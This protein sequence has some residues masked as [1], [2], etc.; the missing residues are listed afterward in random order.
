M[1]ATSITCCLHVCTTLEIDN[2]YVLYRMI[3]KACELLYSWKHVCG[4]NMY[5]IA[6]ELEITGTRSGHKANKAYL[7]YS[8]NVFEMDEMNDETKLLKLNRTCDKSEKKPRCHNSQSSSSVL[9]TVTVMLY[10]NAMI[11]WQISFQVFRIKLVKITHST[12]LIFHFFSLV[13]LVRTEHVCLL[14]NLNQELRK[15]KIVSKKYSNKFLRKVFNE[16]CKL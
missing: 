2:D 12:N 13:S 10:Y 11:L 8:A 7:L 4:C 9:F 14:L 15:Y 16:S 5:I 1:L 6:N 3:L